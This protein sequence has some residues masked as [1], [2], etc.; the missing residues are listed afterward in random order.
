M[1]CMIKR[2]TLLILLLQ[3][4]AVVDYKDVPALAR[5]ILFGAPDQE[6]TDSFYENMPYSFAKIRIGRSRIGFMVLLSIENDIYEWIGSYDERILTKHGKIISTSGL[7]YNINFIN[8]GDSNVNCDNCSAT[9][10]I[11]LDNPEA[12]LIQKVTNSFVK[13]EEI[14]LMNQ[15]SVASYVEKFETI[16]L[17]WKG[18]NFYWFNNNGQPIKSVQEIHP[19]LGKIEITFFYK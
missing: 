17:R 18:E 9:Y 11:Q 2:F 4:C 6:V 14:S 12:L 1:I 10:Q 15:K 16:K 3:S 19:T 13:N 5:S 7:D 8:S